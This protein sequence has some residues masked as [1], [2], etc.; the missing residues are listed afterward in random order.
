MSLVGGINR[1][2]TYISLDVKLLFPRMEMS[3]RRRC[4]PIGGIAIRRAP[5]L[6]PEAGRRDLP[7]G[8]VPDTM[9][10]RQQDSLVENT[11]GE[12]L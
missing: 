7:L 5:P 2:V 10:V 1:I 9:T 8:P 6:A 12:D 3:T 11:R 4:K